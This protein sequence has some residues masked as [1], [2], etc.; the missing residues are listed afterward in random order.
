MSAGN[1]MNLYQVGQ[2]GRPIET[3]HQGDLDEPGAKPILERI[4]NALKLYVEVIRD[5]R[6]M[7]HQAFLADRARRF[8]EQ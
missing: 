5:M 2:R 8:G 1:V 3:I 4:V 7:Q 6:D